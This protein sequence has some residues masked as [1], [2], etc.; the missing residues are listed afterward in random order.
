MAL[1]SVLAP[2]LSISNFSEIHSVCR[3]SFG[4]TDYQLYKLVPLQEGEHTDHVVVKLNTH[5]SLN[6]VE[7]LIRKNEILQTQ[8]NK[9]K[10]AVKTY[11]IEFEKIKASLTLTRSQ[12]VKKL[13]EENTKL[14]KALQ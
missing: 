13:E 2:A 6:A 4:T 14:R 12:R 1:V 5:F 9:A 7:D 11:S 10:E 8:L 3:D